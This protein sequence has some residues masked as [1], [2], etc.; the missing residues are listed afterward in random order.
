[1]GPT[2]KQVEHLATERPGMDERSLRRKVLN[3]AHIS[4]KSEFSAIPCTLREVSETGCRIITEGGWFSPEQF[5][6]HVDIDCYK[7]AC[8]RVWQC[9]SECGARFIGGKINTGTAQQQVIT[10]SIDTTKLPQ[11]RPDA[12]AND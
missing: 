9:G 10:S 8:K 4:F 1:M 3:G 2:E 12:N 6:L 7:V 5:T 11:T